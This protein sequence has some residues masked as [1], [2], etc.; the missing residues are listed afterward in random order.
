M[1]GKDPCFGDSGGPL[2]L[3]ENDRFVINVELW[4]PR[5]SITCFCTT[6]GKHRSELSVEEEQTQEIEDVLTPQGPDFIWESHISRNGSRIK[7]M[8]L[9]WT[10][11]ANLM[12]CRC[13]LNM[14]PIYL[15]NS[16]FHPPHEVESSDTQKKV[17]LILIPNHAVWLRQPFSTRLF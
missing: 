14:H 4:W 17:C 16:R 8:E 6:S 2:F 7:Q 1:S 13:M 15:V 3:T 11:T 9:Q 5:E 10:A 12:F